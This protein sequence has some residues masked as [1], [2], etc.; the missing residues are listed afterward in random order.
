MDTIGANR[1]GCCTSGLGSAITG[2]EADPGVPARLSVLTARAPAGVAVLHQAGA[3]VRL[4][5]GSCVGIV[6]VG[7]D[8]VAPQ[9]PL[10]MAHPIPQVPVLHLQVAGSL[11]QLGD[12]ER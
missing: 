1:G 2:C 4:R 11:G 10:Q 3:L 6:V 12:L 8:R 7:V 5:S 9:H